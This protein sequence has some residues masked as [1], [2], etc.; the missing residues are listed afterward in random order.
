MYGPFVDILA[1]ILDGE[2]IYSWMLYNSIREGCA[3]FLYTIATY[4]LPLYIDNVVIG[5]G[6]SPIITKHT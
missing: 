3:L 6:R 4:P 2:I 1:F 5:E